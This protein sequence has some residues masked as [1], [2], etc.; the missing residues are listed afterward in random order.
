MNEWARDF[1]AALRDEEDPRC[2]PHEGRKARLSSRHAG[3]L[4]CLRRPDPFK[5]HDSLPSDSW[6]PCKSFRERPTLL[7][8]DLLESHTVSGAEPREETFRS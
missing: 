5:G 6:T 4:A 2:D 3:S 1:P 8:R 7:D